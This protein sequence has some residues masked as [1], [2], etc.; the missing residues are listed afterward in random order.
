[1]IPYLQDPVR[2]LPV[3]RSLA[4][5]LQERA[6]LLPDAEARERMTGRERSGSCRNGITWATYSSGLNRRMYSALK[7]SSLR[8]SLRGPA[9]AISAPETAPAGPAGSP[10]AYSRPVTT[11][12]RIMITLRKAQDRGHAQHGW[13]DSWHSFSFARAD[14]STRQSICM[15]CANKE[16]SKKSNFVRC[17]PWQHRWLRTLYVKSSNR[18]DRWGGRDQR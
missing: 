13:L 16:T 4:S 15:H 1:M 9:A 6:R 3:I 18:L 5:V 11:E 17:S 12:D 8:S 7:C 14:T 10:G 2:S